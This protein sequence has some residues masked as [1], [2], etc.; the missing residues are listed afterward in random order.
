M[1]RGIDNIQGSPDKAATCVY[2]FRHSSRDFSLLYR[3]IGHVRSLAPG[4]SVAPTCRLY[5]TR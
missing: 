4:D 5:K 1:R 3:P 2:D